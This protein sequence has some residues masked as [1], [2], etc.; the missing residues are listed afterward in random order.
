M[1]LKVDSANVHDTRF[2]ALIAQ[3]QE[4]MIVLSD[5]GFKAK[6]DNPT[7]LKVCGKGTWDERMLIET[8]FS[9][10]T[11]VLGLRKLSQRVWP[12]LRARLAYTVAAFN[13]CTAWNGEVKLQL[14]P[15]AL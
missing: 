14:A 7:N 1:W 12:V 10:L 13:L 4:Q 9:L 8:L 2:Q 15:F 6:A 11:V 3:F 5:R